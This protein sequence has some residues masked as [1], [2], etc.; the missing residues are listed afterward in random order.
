[1]IDETWPSL[2]L[3]AWQDTYATLHL[4]MQIVG[5]TRLALSPRVN[6]WWNVT[7]Y[8]TPRGLTTSAM[9]YGDRTFSVDFDFI[10]HILLVRT[11]DGLAGTLPLAPRPV[12]EFYQE[13]EALLGSLGLE[14]R[15]WPVP[16]EIER[17]IPFAED[18][19]HASYD[20][21]YAHRFWRALAQ[22][23]RVL[24]IFRGRF[25]GKCSPVHF[26]WGGCDLA[27]TRFSGRRAPEHPGGIPNLADWVTR[28][29]YS[30]EVSSCGFWPGGGLVSEPAFYAYA[31]P[32]PAGFAE[33]PIQPREAFYHPELREFLLP[34]EAVR[35]AER[36]DDV[37]LAFLQSTYEAAAEPG[38]WDR[39][40]LERSEKVER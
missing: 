6:H 19:E 28:E 34:Y 22:A 15:I 39:K 26:F 35:T 1:M 5:K 23:D 9:P 31:Y 40:M 38:G 3:Q 2:P 29:S 11:S 8:L 36:P 20:A 7:F 24:Q 16:V 10:D 21:A 25:L 17:V 30:H 18:R 32:E 13:Y 27:V 4:W 37:L 12:A 33:F 14:V